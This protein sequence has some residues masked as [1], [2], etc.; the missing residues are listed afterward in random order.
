MK[1]VL[2]ALLAS[3]LLLPMSPSSNALTVT[4]RDPVSQIPVN[5]T[6][7]SSSIKEIVSLNISWD[8]MSF[9]YIQEGIQWNPTKHDYETVE[10]HWTDETAE[11][12]LTNHSN[13]GISA[14]FSFT[15]AEGVNINGVFSKSNLGITSA[16]NYNYKIPDENGVLPAPTSST[17]FSISPESDP[18][19]ENKTLG[20]ISISLSTREAYLDLSGIATGSY[21]SKIKDYLFEGE[22][23]L[24]VKL[25]YE[26]ITLTEAKALTAAINSVGI[27]ACDLTIVDVKVIESEAFYSTSNR[28]ANA[29]VIRT[30]SAPNLTEIK[31]YAFNGCD[32][33]TGISMPKLAKV[34]ER[35]FNNCHGLTTVYLPELVEIGLKGFQYCKGLKEINMPKL[36]TIGN[37]GFC[38]CPALEKAYCPLAETVGEYAFSGCKMLYEID[39]SSV[40]TLEKSVLYVCEGITSLSFPSVTAAKSQSLFAMSNMTSLSFGSVITSLE[41]NWA[42]YYTAS[43]HLILNKDQGDVGGYRTV[44]G[45]NGSFGGY[46]FASVTKSN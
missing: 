19:E 18:I 27:T 23:A 8:T 3:T 39:L 33:L 12:T 37:N 28:N 31:R 9:G 25:G 7:D 1:K 16:D 5:G 41:K 17:E 22:T 30:F 15:S 14:D 21:A 13:V 43:I 26:T 35:G 45:V 11:I 10:A 40:K 4:S 42:N 38:T 44:E 32:Q 46:T 34:G 24:S 20:S 6:Y 29:D 36:K 2:A